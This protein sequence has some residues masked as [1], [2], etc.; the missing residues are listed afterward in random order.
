DPVGEAVRMLATLVGLSMLLALV[1]GIL[2]LAG[3][4]LARR[5]RARPARRHP[6]P[7]S[8]CCCPWSAPPSPW[9]A[10]CSPGGCGLARPVATPSR[11]PLG[12][13]PARLDGRRP[14]VSVSPGP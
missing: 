12:S 8:P 13:G 14:R 6:P 2:T 5:L 9:P 3:C 7:P 1:G 10:A 4:L 11:P